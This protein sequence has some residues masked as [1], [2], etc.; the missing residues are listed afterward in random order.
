MDLEGLLF[1]TSYLKTQITWRT[2]LLTTACL[3]RNLESTFHTKS[4]SP[5]K[6]KFW[7]LPFSLWSNWKREKRCVCVRQTDRWLHKRKMTHVHR[8][9]G[10]TLMATSK[11]CLVWLF[12]WGHIYWTSMH[13]LHTDL[14][15]RPLISTILWVIRMMPPAG[16]YGGVH[17]GH[18]QLLLQKHS[19]SLAFLVISQI[20][21]GERFASSSVWVLRL[22]IISKPLIMQTDVCNGK[23]HDFTDLSV[24]RCM[25]GRNA[26]REAVIYLCLS[27]L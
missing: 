9:L 15:N 19:V 27:Q 23:V 8:R 11:H 25:P 7:E 18:N 2:W 22:L 21:E 10:Y 1:V 26:T 4:L 24:Q 5:N 20:Y 6:L 13:W 14:Q 17:S 12:Y 16:V 3:L